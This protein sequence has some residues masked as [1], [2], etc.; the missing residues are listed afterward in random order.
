MKNNIMDKLMQNY[1][2]YI[3]VSNITFY[4]LYLLNS[5]TLSLN[6]RN[7]IFIII[8]SLSMVMIPVLYLVIMTKREKFKNVYMYLN[9]IIVTTCFDILLLSISSEFSFTYLIKS[10]LLSIFIFTPV[11]LGIAMIIS[12]TRNIPKQLN[13]KNASN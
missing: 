8:A 3:G 2:K 12:F 6:A 11:R 13:F 1:F 5:K 10:I 7:I 4:L 9:I